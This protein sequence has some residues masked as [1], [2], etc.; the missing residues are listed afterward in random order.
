MS[1]PVLAPE[2]QL[3]PVM[4]TASGEPVPPVINREWPVS[5]ALTPIGH[6]VIFT[7]AVTVAVSV[8]PGACGVKLYVLAKMRFEVFPPPP[9]FCEL[10]GPVNQLPLWQVVT[11]PVTAFT[12]MNASGG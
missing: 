9:V 5:V 3:P 6:G 1:C 12:A 4:R 8:P 7:T 11:A 10:A 2:V